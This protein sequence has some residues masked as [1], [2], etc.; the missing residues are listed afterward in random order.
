M[1][2]K[3]FKGLSNYLNSRETYLDSDFSISTAPAKNYDTDLE[4]FWTQASNH[5]YVWKN[6]LFLNQVLNIKKRCMTFFIR[7]VT[8]TS[9]TS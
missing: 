9:F 3:C 8:F 4:N 1:F 6:T 7:F 5:F 2:C